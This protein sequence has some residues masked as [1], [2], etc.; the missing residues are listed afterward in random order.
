MPSKHYTLPTFPVECDL[1]DRLAA[2]TRPIVVYGMG[3][4]ADK[5][6]SRLSEYSV[7]VSDVFASDGFVRG[8]S[9]RGMRV[10]SFSEVREKYDDFV[11]LL[12]F[13]TSRPE[14]LEMLGEINEKYEMYIPDM[15]VAGEA[16]YFD[17]EFYNTHYAELLKA[18]NSLADGES[19]DLFAAAVNYKLTGKMHYL[20]DCYSSTEELYSLLP[21]E[22]IE[23]YIDV[24]AYNGDTL[25]E[26]RR[27]FPNLKEAIA[28]EPDPKTYKRLLKYADTVTDYTLK[29]VNAAAFDR[30]GDG[31][32]Q[33]AG[34]RNSSI[35]STAS[36]E[37][38]AA[39]IPL[40]RVDSLAERCDYIKYDVE[41]SEYEALVGSHGL[42]EGKYPSLLV[43][44]Y[45]R[46]RDI[47][48]L[49]NYINESYS[50]Y[51]LYLRRTLSVPCW[52]LA[53]LCL[54][55]QSEGGPDE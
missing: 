5:L 9:Y 2:E 37:H 43:S 15:P 42:I 3:N 54:G 14:V 46:S 50:G 17:R 13:A 48:S 31:E 23:S 52:E 20:T 7:T 19:R 1:W 27:F 49:V 36:Y 24:G 39:S 30:A 25:R 40:V 16:E 11:I 6:F 47:F 55:E 8:H 18:Y 28:I 12:S 22:K 32:F 34:N 53:L 10:L 44:L 26:S 4:G 21:C 33:S 51:R 41:G 38:R 29:T 35:C 45:H